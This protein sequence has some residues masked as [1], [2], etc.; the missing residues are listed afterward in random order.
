MPS[1][2]ETE[3]RFN[4]ST[5][6]AMPAMARPLSPSDD[7][8]SPR[9]LDALPPAAGSV[10]ALPP[11]PDPLVVAASASE[12]SVLLLLLGGWLEFCP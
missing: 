1:P 7:P 11:A 6:T 3:L 9:V 10:T 12:A 4:S 5:P 2:M 8:P